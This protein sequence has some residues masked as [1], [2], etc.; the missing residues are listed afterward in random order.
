[1]HGTTARIK[2]TEHV[3]T[4]GGLVHRA[5]KRDGFFVLAMCTQRG[6]NYRSFSELA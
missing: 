1:M 3:T 4:A 2:S 5:S 6:A